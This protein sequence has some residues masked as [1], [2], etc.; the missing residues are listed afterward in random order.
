MF[1]LTLIVGCK[2]HQSHYWSFLYKQNYG[3]TVCY[4]MLLCVQDELTTYVGRVLDGAKEKWSKGEE[5]TREDGC[6]VIPV[7]YDIIQVQNQ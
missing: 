3:K 4:N 2:E 5:P 1:V 6:F 7:A